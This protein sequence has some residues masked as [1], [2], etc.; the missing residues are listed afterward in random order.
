MLVGDLQAFVYLAL[1]QLLGV[2]GCRQFHYARSKYLSVINPI[3]Q[4]GFVVLRMR[5]TA[6]VVADIHHAVGAVAEN[7]PNCPCQDAL[8]CHG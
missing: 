1:Q 3:D 5:M 8:R 4:Y 2:S 7:Q 6:N